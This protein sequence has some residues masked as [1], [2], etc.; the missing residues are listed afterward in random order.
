MIL[1]LRG[2]GEEIICLINPF[3]ALAPPEQGLGLGQVPEPVGL[4][5]ALEEAS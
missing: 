1:R 3:P 5:R 4:L 2:W